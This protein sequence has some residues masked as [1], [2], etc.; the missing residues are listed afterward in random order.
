MT[1][2]PDPARNLSPAAIR[3]AV[4]G[5]SLQ[6]P[7]VVYPA[8]LGILGGV[9]ALVVAGSPLVFGAAMLAGGAAAAA[10]AA[11]YFVRHDRIAGSYLAEVRRQMAAERGA[12]IT[13]LAAD[14]KEVKSIE[15]GRQLDRFAD[16]SATFQAVLSER[17]SPQELTFAR[18]SAI[19]EAVF[20]AGIDNLRAIHLSLKTLQAIDERYIRERLGQL[21][22]DKGG[23]RD[24]ETKGLQDQ[25]AQATSLRERVRARLGQN[26]LAIAELDRATAAIGEMRTGSDRPTLDMESAMQELARIAQRSAE[27]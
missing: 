22:K 9:G 3:L 21:E 14:L 20:L 25:L 18:F 7:A 26:E 11:N 27:Y 1:S 2:F 10:L 6:H 12:R 15:A 23:G 13:D 16:K 8:V 24:S 19:A 5:Q 4:L 17:L